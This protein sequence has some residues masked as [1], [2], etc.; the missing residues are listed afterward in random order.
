MIV[1]ELVRE[2]EEALTESITATNSCNDVI[3]IMIRSSCSSSRMSRDSGSRVR[4]AR[5]P[6][7][8]DE[9]HNHHDMFRWCLQNESV[10]MNNN[11]ASGTVL[12]DW[13]GGVISFTVDNTL[14]HNTP[15]S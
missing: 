6:A 4:L 12:F 5:P 14:Y 2:E 15:I 11:N 10:R 13:T 3:T 9:C 7:K 8:V 1:R